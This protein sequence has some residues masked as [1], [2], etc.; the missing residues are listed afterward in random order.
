MKKLLLLLLFVSSTA[1]AQHHHG[2]W[3]HGGDNRWVW[4]APF[5]VGGVIGYEVAQA[6][7]PVVVT[8]PPVVIQQPPVIIQQNNCSPWTQIRNPDGTVTVT[9]TCTQ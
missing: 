3:R 6:K 4:M 7:P 9:R 2:Y 1:M 8:Q 5:V